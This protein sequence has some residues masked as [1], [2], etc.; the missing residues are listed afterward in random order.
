LK[1]NIKKELINIKKDV[2]EVNGEGEDIK[3]LIKRYEYELK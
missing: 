2:R 1:T 3:G